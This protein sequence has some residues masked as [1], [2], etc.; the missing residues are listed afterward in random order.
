MTGVQTCALP[1]SCETCESKWR[2]DYMNHWKDSVCCD[3]RKREPNSNNG[4][5][6]KAGSMDSTKIGVKN[7][8]ITGFPGCSK[9]E[10]GLGSNYCQIPQSSSSILTSSSSSIF[11]SSSYSSSSEEISSSSEE[12]EKA[13]C[14]TTGTDANA[15][16][17]DAEWKCSRLGKNPNY[18]IDYYNCLVGEC[19]EDR[20][21]VV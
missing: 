5:C 18:E 2:D 1:I 11:S 17:F 8:K 20:K 7:S 4:T 15:A 16:L 3:E 19:I 6:Q 14:Y 13:D 12:Q 9:N 21:S 10:A